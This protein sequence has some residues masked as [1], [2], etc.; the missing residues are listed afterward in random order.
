MREPSSQPRLSFV[1]EQSRTQGVTRH[2]TKASVRGPRKRSHCES[3]PCNYKTD[4]C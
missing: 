1:R 3:S 2:I 4:R